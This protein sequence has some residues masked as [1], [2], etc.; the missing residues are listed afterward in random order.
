MIPRLTCNI[1]NSATKQVGARRGMYRTDK[2][3]VLRRCEHCLFSFVENPDTDY[4]NLY[5]LDYYRGRGADPLID[6][7]YEWSH[8]TKTIRQYEWSAILKIVRALTHKQTA[9][10]WLDY[11]CGNGGLVSFAR[12]AGI[13]GVIGYEMGHITEVAQRRGLP[14][15]S[16]NELGQLEGKCHVVTAIEVFE[17]LI[18][19]LETLRRCAAM[20][21]DGGV[22]FYTTGNA[23]PHRKQLYKWNYVR[24]EIHVS[25]FEPSTMDVALRL[26]GMKPLY[27]TR[28]RVFEDIIRYKILKNLGVRNTSWYLDRLPWRGLCALADRRFGISRFPIGIRTRTFHS[29]G[30]QGGIAPVPRS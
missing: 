26:C 2:L 14:I 16:E 28:G 4:E 24:P 20:L 8:P 7:E 21:R 9:I 29:I 30:A 18:D 3:Y 19:P 6:F 22:L 11:G 5:N 1:C 23:E 12:M 17:H 15:I 13:S 25:F 27:W 10:T